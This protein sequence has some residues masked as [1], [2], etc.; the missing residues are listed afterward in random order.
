MRERVVH[1]RIEGTLEKNGQ[2]YFRLHYWSEGPSKSVEVEDLVRKDDHGYFTIKGADKGT[3]EEREL[4][5]P[6]KVG[7]TWESKGKAKV[8]K[9]T[10]V[11]LETVAIGEM[12]FANCFHLQTV[13]QGEQYTADSWW[14]PNV[15]LVKSSS[16]FEPGSKVTRTLVEFK[17]GK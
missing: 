10:V 6:L 12:T 5:L 15:G 17:R 1:R 8:S 4:V 13:V 7:A 2:T 3:T 9:V 11:G 16:A 14:A